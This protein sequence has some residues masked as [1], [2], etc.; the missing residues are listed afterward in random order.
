VSGSGLRG[1]KR[2]FGIWRP[3]AE[4]H[5]PEG[6]RGGG[7][8]AES[9]LLINIAKVGKKEAER[10]ERKECAKTDFLMW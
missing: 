7:N 5:R 2:R 9:H 1:K 8:R 6:E 3:A 4:R 10:E